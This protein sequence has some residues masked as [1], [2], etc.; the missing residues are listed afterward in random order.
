MKKHYFIILLVVLCVAGLNSFLPAQDNTTVPQVVI[1]NGGRFETNP[2][3]FDYVTVGYYNPTTQVYTIFDTIYTQSV[4]DVLIS[5]HFAYVAA[6]DSLVKYDLDT[7]QRLATVAD[8]G[9][10]KLGLAG[11]KLVVTKGFPVVRF[12]VE[13]LDAANLTV[14][15][16]I[17]NISGDCGTAIATNDSLYVAV[18]GGY[19]GTEGK[20]AVI[21]T[22]SWT[23]IHEVNFG[24]DAVGIW[25]LYGWGGY[26]YT[27]NVTPGGIS[28]IGSITKFNQFDETFSTHILDVTVGNGVGIMGSLLYTGFNYGIGSYD[29]NTDQIADTVIVR[30]PGSA[31]HIYYLAT[32]LDW[33]NNEFY[34]NV[35]NY[36]NPGKCVI[37][38]IAGDSLTSFSDGISSNA[39]AIEFY[40]PAGIH[41]GNAE[42][43]ILTF[44]VNGWLNITFNNTM[45]NYGMTILDITGRTIYSSELKGTEKTLKVN[46]SGFS[47]GVYF[48]SLNTNNG[49]IVKK[50]IKQ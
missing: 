49:T 35:G 34:L 6:Q 50:F 47:P 24:P 10:V 2:P 9:M 3:Y 27:V 48:L 29:L 4:Q 43:A 8:S 32:A 17:D 22:T 12:F 46:T 42:P 16:L 13:I 25:N 30:D 21:S 18:N 19:L 7:H 23:V 28:G 37:T 11:D 5:D 33:V 1:A 15:S 20:L 26:I 40:T 31:N 45:Q 14:S 44:P 38:T 39:L 41:N 36:T